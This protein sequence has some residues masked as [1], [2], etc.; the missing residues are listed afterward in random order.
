[1]T[2]VGFAPFTSTF[3]TGTQVSPID[4]SIQFQHVAL[5]NVPTGQYT[6][7]TIGPD[8]KLYAAG[9]TATSTAGTSWPTARSRP[10][11]RSPSLP[12]CQRRRI[13]C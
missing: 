12:R 4:N 8:G 3:T 13:G 10:W 7:V 1:M 5:A 6:A 11:R 2:G 9:V